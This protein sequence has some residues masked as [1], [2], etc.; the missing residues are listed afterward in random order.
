MRAGWQ[1]STWEALRCSL[2]A[3]QAPADPGEGLRACSQG[4]REHLE[5]VVCRAALGVT[6]CL[7]PGSFVTNRGKEGRECIG[8]QER[9]EG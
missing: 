6:S 7:L 3:L 1:G 5:G 9:R 4:D 2:Q 8:E